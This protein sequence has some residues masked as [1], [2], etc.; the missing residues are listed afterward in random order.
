MPVHTSPAKEKYPVTKSHAL[1]NSADIL[2]PSSPKVKNP[3]TLSHISVNGVIR[4]T[5]SHQSVIPVNIPVI[6]FHASLIFSLIN[7]QENIAAIAVNPIV[8]AAIVPDMPANIAKNGAAAIK[9]APINGAAMMPPITANA[10]TTR[11]SQSGNRLLIM[12]LN[13]SPITGPTF[14]EIQS[15]AS[16]KAII[17]GPSSFI[18]FPKSP[19]TSTSWEPPGPPSTSFVP[20]NNAVL[21]SN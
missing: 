20:P 12:P 8:I 21:R 17:N 11:V 1:P 14:V 19:A 2:N 7:S 16:W 13:I 4:S 15:A 10:P 3:V 5:V 9:A 6:E 18:K